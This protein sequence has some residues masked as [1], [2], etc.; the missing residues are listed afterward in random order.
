MKTMRHIVFLIRLTCLPVVVVA[1]AIV[2]AYAHG[3]FKT[4]LYSVGYFWWIATNSWRKQGENTNKQT[5]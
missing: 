2:C 5:N 1:D 3:M 4:S